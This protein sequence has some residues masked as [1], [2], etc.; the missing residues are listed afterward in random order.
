MKPTV[1]VMENGV[2]HL[3]V[4]L[5]FEIGREEWNQYRLLDGGTVRVKTT[6]LRMVQL[7]DAAG[8]LA[9]NDDGTPRIQ[10][11]HRVDVVSEL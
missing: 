10:I 6:V 3:A 4:P 7:L 5:D 11:R 9:V 2:E 1:K 8:N